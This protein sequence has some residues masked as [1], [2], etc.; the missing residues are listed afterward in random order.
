MINLII[1]SVPAVIVPF[2]PAVLAALVTAFFAAAFI[3]PVRM[4]VPMA[5][6]AGRAVRTEF[7]IIRH[8]KNSF[9]FII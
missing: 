4:F 2:V 8:R 7:E 1:A 3:T 6:A 5:A 9:F